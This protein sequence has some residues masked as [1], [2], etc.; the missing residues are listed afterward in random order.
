MSKYTKGPWKVWRERIPH[1]TILMIVEARENGQS[2]GEAYD[3]SDAYLIAAAPE[4]YEAARNA[5]IDMPTG[6]S[7]DALIDALLKAEGKDT[8]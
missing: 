8:K 4:L 5:L 7:K 3:E 6:P 2:V 1:R